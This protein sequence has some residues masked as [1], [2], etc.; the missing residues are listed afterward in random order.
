MNRKDA[1]VKQE[2]KLVSPGKQSS[3]RFFKIKMGM[4]TRFDTKGTLG[5]LGALSEAGG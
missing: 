2:Q 5:V 3:Q 1:P 4:V